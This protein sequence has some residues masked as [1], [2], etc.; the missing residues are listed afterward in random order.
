MSVVRIAATHGVPGA[1][2]ACGTR[3]LYPAALSSRAAWS[4]AGRL[5]SRTPVTGPDT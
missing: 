1:T 4:N 5:P 3:A 2:S